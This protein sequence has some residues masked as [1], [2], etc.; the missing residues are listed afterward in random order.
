MLD[1]SRC[2]GRNENEVGK[3]LKILQVKFRIYHPAIYA[4]CAACRFKKGI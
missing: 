2:V 4:S 3:I 1:N